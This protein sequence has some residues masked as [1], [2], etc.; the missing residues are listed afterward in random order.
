VRVAHG[1]EDP[2][3]GRHVTVFMRVEGEQGHGRATNRLAAT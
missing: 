2:G 3:D 1:A